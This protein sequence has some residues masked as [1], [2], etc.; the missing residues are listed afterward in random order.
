[1]LAKFGAAPR[2]TGLFIVL[3]FAKLLYEAA[4]FQEFLEPPQGGPNRLPVVKTHP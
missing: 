1:L 3:A 4:P 2:L